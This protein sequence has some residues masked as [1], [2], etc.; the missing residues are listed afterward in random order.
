MKLPG[1]GNQPLRIVPVSERSGDD[2]IRNGSPASRRNTLLLN[3]RQPREVRRAAGPELGSGLPRRPEHNRSALPPTPCQFKRVAPRSNALIS[4]TGFGKNTPA[5]ACSLRASEKQ[6]FSWQ[7]RAATTLSRC[8]P[9]PAKDLPDGLALPVSRKWIESQAA[10]HGRFR[11]V[12]MCTD[13]Q[14]T[15]RTF[16][17]SVLR[18]AMQ[19]L[20]R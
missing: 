19:Q 4:A 8:N 18:I 2:P 3:T 6:T 9:D 20:H 1:K 15:L 7:I 11:A 14:C 13:A 17:P 5:V 16:R 10:T 12:R